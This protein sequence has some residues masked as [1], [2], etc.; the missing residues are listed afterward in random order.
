MLHHPIH[1]HDALVH[2]IRHSGIVPGEAVRAGRKLAGKEPRDFG[3][4]R[5]DDGDA[6]V[7]GGAGG[8]VDGGGLREWIGESGKVAPNRLYY[9]YYAQWRG[10]F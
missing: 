4:Q 2:A 1:P 5:I 10:K 8:E 6:R 7:P 3:S 9:G